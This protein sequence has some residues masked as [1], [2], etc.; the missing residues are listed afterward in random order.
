MN[1]HDQPGIEVL[2][3]IEIDSPV[4]TLTLVADHDA[5]VAVLWPDDDPS[6]V[7]LTFRAVDAGNSE[8]LGAAAS[9]LGE[10]FAGTRTE[11]E[12][13]LA[14]GGTDFQSV[15]WAA[16]RTIEYGQTWT[17]GELATAIGRP[18]A[19]RAVG[20]ANGRNPLSIVVPCHRVVASTG[21]LAG[22]AGGLATKR[23]LLD[24][25]QNVINAREANT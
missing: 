9:Q 23:Q 16:L 2:E 19:A 21:G 18:T 3:S 5:L 6:R 4:G 1:K 22:F 14:P 13:N 11:F 25:E 10:Y 12:L 17:Y 8:V 15:V 20:T 7:R 24:L